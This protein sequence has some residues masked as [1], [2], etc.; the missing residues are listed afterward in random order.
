[1]DELMEAAATNVHGRCED[2]T[3]LEVEEWSNC[4]ECVLLNFG[5]GI[6][7]HAELAEL[8]TDSQVLAPEF[9]P[10]RGG[11]RPRAR[12]WEA[13]LNEMLEVRNRRPRKLR[14]G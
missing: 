14:H 10:T 5:F 1:M 4:L 11:G 3:E 6:A 9:E 7:P 13:A 2:D 12:S 8:G